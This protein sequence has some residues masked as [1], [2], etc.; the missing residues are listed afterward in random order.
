MEFI[1]FDLDGTLIDLEFSEMVW[2]YGIPELY[3]RSKE[4]DFAKA[5]DFV[6][7]E[8]QKIG[9]DK[10]EWY[11]IKFWFRH[12]NL[13]ESW[14]EFIQ[15]FKYK[16]TVYPEVR[17]VLKNLSKKHELIIIS[18]SAREFVELGMETGRIRDYFTHVFSATSDFNQV[19]KT[20]EFY[21]QICAILRIEVQELIHVG[22]HWEFDYLAPR[23][24]GINSFYL[25]R[26]GKKKEEFIINN[27]RELEKRLINYQ[28]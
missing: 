7:G 11:D 27:L 4:I 12:F 13:S 1:S 6:I 25:D 26:T 22:D 5:K 23:K 9:D 10:V 18:N 17:D 8:Y 16:I 20:P 21:L 15:R 28:H 19:K 14:Q 2:H 24:I 3:A